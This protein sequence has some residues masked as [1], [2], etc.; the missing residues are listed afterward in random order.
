MTAW[1]LCLLF[2]LV[3]YPKEEGV[4]PRVANIIRSFTQQECHLAVPY[5]KSLPKIFTARVHRKIYLGS[6]AGEPV[7]YFAELP[8][9]KKG[10]GMR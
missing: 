2:D 9:D 8:N 5:L 4:P 3:S 6:E 7:L 1:N 10:R